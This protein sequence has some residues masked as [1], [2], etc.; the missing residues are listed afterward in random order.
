MT[1][2]CLPAALVSSLL[3]VGGPTL[4]QA[5][6]RSAP[7]SSTEIP[8]K[9]TTDVWAFSASAFGYVIP[10]GQSYGQPTVT[11]DRGWLHLE[12]RYNYEA[13]ETGSTWVGY[14]FDGGDRITW[15]F[16]PMVGGVF[17]DLNGIAPGY[18]AT[19][20]WWKIEFYTEGEYVFGLGDDP[21][22]FF[23]SWSELS[24]APVEWFRV[25]MVVQRT[26]VYDSERDVQRGILA[27]FTY[28]WLDFTAYLF[29][30]D[31]S[32]PLVVLGLGLEF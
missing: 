10:D 21:E 25:G 29:N 24:I 6:D 1:P 15:A 31:D 27:G 13:L 16:T 7:A 26:R 32:K 11:A 17:G 23:Y 8:T 18:L 9:D 3:A 20:G 14:N 5:P 2:R 12:A 30:P 19:L 28:R 4:A 22:D